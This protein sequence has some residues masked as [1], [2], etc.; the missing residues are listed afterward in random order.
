M[1]NALAEDIGGNRVSSPMQET[2][3]KADLVR[4]LRELENYLESIGADVST[5]T[6]AQIKARMER[7][8]AQEVAAQYDQAN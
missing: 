7:S 3:A 6:N 5:M 2:Q 1:L 8:E 4:G